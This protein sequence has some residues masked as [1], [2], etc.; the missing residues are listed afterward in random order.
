[1][2]EANWRFAMSGIEDADCV[3]MAA[4]VERGQANG[5]SQRPGSLVLSSRKYHKIHLMHF[6][7]TERREYKRS[8]GMVF[9]EVK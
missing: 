9:H 8:A 4:T 3:Q 5:E 1:M 2:S 6:I 7:S